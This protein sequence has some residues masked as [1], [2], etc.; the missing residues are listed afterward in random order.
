MVAKIQQ[1]DGQVF[2]FLRLF[3]PSNDLLGSKRQGH[4]PPIRSKNLATNW[5]VTGACHQL[6]QHSGG[7]NSMKVQPTATIPPPSPRQPHLS[8][9]PIARSAGTYSSRTHMKLS[10]T[11]CHKQRC[12][13]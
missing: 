6:Q 12:H 13:R 4:T 2:L 10:L 9:T 3:M 11:H 7:D 1:H 5:T 8:V